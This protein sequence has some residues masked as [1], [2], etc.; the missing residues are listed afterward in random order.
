M[1]GINGA[2]S[3]DEEQ[4][5][6][7][8]ARSLWASLIENEDNRRLIRNAVFIDNVLMMK[9]LALNMNKGN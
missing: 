7:K 4:R 3:A 2:T 1:A 9:M 8:F 6:L 5:K